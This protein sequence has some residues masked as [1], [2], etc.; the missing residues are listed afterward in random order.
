MWNLQENVYAKACFIFFL[1]IYKWAKHGLRLQ[2]WIEMAVWKHTD[3]PVK[4]NTRHSRQ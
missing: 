4:K 3:S 1:D 2:T